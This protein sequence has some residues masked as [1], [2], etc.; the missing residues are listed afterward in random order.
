MT[1]SI[2][3]GNIF[4]CVCTYIGFWYPFNHVLLLL[5]ELQEAD[6]LI[7]PAPHYQPKIYQKIVKSIYEYKWII[8][9]ELHY[10]MWGLRFSCEVCEGGN[11]Y[12][13]VLLAQVFFVSKPKALIVCH[14]TVVIFLLCQW[15]F[16]SLPPEESYRPSTL[17]ISLRSVR[18]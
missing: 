14:I 16:L 3:I 11:G 7:F 13:M 5:S 8:N 17:P 1:R 18:R 12:T 15:Q 2:Y 10:E 9:I 4:L 6:F